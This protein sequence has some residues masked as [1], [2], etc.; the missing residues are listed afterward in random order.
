MVHVTDLPE[1]TTGELIEEQQ[2]SK[3]PIPAMTQRVVLLLALPIIGENLLQT[4]VGAVDTL[5]VS[6]IG[7][8]AI[9]GVGVGAELVFFMLA[10]LSAV[11]VGAT[12]LVSQAI[13]SGDK[14]RS[15]QLARQA[16]TWGI[17]IAIPLSIVGYFATPALVG[18]FGAEPQ[19][20]D[21]AISYF[22]VIASTS[23][24]LLLSFLCGAVLRGAGD[25]RTPLKAAV[26][27]NIVNIFLSYAL[28]FG[29]LGLPE[30]GVAGSAWGASIGRGTAAAFML[31]ML[32]R[33]KGPLS[34]HGKI[35]WRPE[36]K[37][38][39]DLFR[40]G[41]PAAI[42]QGMMEAGFMSLVMIVAT[43]GTAALAAQQISFTAM[44]LGFLP[45]IGFAVTA[46]ALVGQSIGAR[47]ID[48]ALTAFRISLRW[49]IVW[50]VGGLVLYV[51]AAEWMIKLFS[52][53]PEVISAG[54]GGLRAIGLSLP[55]W[56][57]WMTSAGSLRGSGDTRSPMVR[58]VITVWLAVVLAFVGVHWFDMGIGWVWLTFLIT[59]P[60]SAVGN[61]RAF[62][63][64]SEALRHEFALDPNPESPEPI[65]VPVYHP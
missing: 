15:N 21:Y 50:M 23:V 3:P 45:A 5:L 47:R 2:S 26:L 57:I 36:R 31:V 40:L 25:S 59:S 11:T 7:D 12:V 10:I 33:G 30:L 41:G 42:E 65:P 60:I 22:Q 51:L 8:D 38:G 53:D 28:I 13:G 61:I 39:R 63:R 16:I 27:A 64:R 4:A 14:E 32:W 52:S 9:A 55:L 37:V 34:I 54:T 20:T 19:V 48:D 56:G 18:L 17:L 24:F 44:S 43:I 49:S 1:T 46:T 35:G 29:H 6:R 62:R 58:G